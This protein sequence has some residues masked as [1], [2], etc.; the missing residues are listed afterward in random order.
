MTT[1]E[2]S[3]AAVM[4]RRS[5]SAPDGG[6]TKRPE[7]AVLCAVQHRLATPPVIA[8]AKA[9]GVFGDH[10]LG[11]FAIATVGAAVSRRRRR[12]WLVAACG[13]AAAHGLAVAVKRVVRRP[14]PHDPRVRVLVGTPSR[15]SFPSSHA[16]STTAAAVLY[17]ALTGQPAIALVVPP[18]LVS[19]MVLGVHYPS[20]V[21]V[22]ALLGAVVGT[23]F[24]QW[25]HGQGVR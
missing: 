2:G 19:R 3:R 22:G 12:E 10:A 20:D 13:V 23:G 18:M 7:T 17:G 21:L 5:D 25:A 6:N 14:R 24:K 8:S 11:W 9:L 4:L 16:A 1:M 15:L